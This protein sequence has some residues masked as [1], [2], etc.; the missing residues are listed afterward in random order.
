MDIEYIYRAPSDMVSIEKCFNSIICSISQK[1]I[2]VRKS[3]VKTFKFLPLTIIYNIIRYAFKS[4]TKRIFH[5]T[6]DVQYVAC[7]MKKNNTVLTIHDCVV[8]HDAS[9]NKLYRLLVYYLWYYLPLK[10]LKYICCI[11]EETK[12]DLISFFPW[13]ESKL[14]VIPS[15]VSTQFHYCPKEFNV[16]CPQI[17]HVGTR[18]NKNLLRVIQALSGIKCHLRIIGKLNDIQM[19]LLK[20]ESTNYSS[21]FNISEED[22]IREYND[23]DIVSFPSLFEGFGLPIIEAQIVGR[24][25]ITSNIEPMKTVGK[26]AVLVNPLSVESI[27]QGFQCVIDSKEIREKCVSDGLNNCKN[28]TADKVSDMYYSL[29]CHML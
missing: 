10:R 12:R 7:L 29:Y 11:S 20:K 27:R 24:P 28:Y 16:D 15:P 3:F 13:V 9:A 5:I 4:R 6:G 18:D 22:I 14:S 19:D 1:D 2:K 21:D 8:L 25:I 17:L 23:A 26:G